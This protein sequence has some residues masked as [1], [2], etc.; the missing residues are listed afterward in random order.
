MAKRKT[1]PFAERTDSVRL[2]WGDRERSGRGPKP[3]LS[4]ERIAEIAIAVADAEGLQ[5]VSMARV[6]REAG[7]TTMALYRY[8]PGKSELIDL[9]VDT[10]IG[11]APDLRAISGGWRPRLHEWARRCWSIF[12][13]HPWSLQAA[14]ARRRIM[15]PNELGWLDSVLGVLA[16]TG[17]SGVEQ[18]QAFLVLIG[19][20]RS[21]AE[22]ATGGAEG[23]SAERWESAIVRLLKG[24]DDRYPGL[25]A[26]I[27]SGAFGPTP[28]DGLAFGLDCILDGLESLIARRARRHRGGPARSSGRR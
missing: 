6:A 7:V 16:E 10:A 24:Q 22:F 25:M 19:H 18:Y 23:L 11:A 15:G 28:G 14:T 12:R 13:Q 4:V 3:S 21:H 26:A 27:S 1:K 8:I 9:M 2:L 17:L 5:A 20:V